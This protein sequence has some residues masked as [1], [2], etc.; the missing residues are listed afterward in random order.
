MKYS[1]PEIVKIFQQFKHI[2]LYTT[3]QDKD[4]NV[5]NIIYSNLT[6]DL[7]YALIDVHQEQGQIVILK[8]KL[9]VKFSSNDEKK[10]E[11]LLVQ[12]FQES[13][14]YEQSHNKAAIYFDKLLNTSRRI[15]AQL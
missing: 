5:L 6:G 13:D 2:Y 15:T 11:L 12:L 8:G 3:T 14:A 10:L 9:E 4:H 7:V 1:M